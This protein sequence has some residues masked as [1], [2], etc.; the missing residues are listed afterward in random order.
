MTRSD[1]V[2]PVTATDL[3]PEMVPGLPTVLPPD[4][5]EVVDTDGDPRLNVEAQASQWRLMWLA[6]RRHRLAVLGL[7]IVALLYFVAAF[8]E[9]LAPFEPA[10]TTAARS[11][12]RR[13]S[14][15]YSTARPRAAGTSP[16]TSSA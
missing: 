10:A 6:F 14:S 15:G 12:T 8:A 16:R 5:H 11:T 1:A 3:P 4:H 7:V 9:F 2:P 13:R